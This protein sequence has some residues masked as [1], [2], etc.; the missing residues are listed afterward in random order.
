MT[1]PHDRDVRGRRAGGADARLR[2]L[3]TAAGVLAC[4]ALVAGCEGENLFDERASRG[5]GQDL[6]PPTVQ[7]LQPTTG[8]SV[9]H[10]DSILVEVRVQDDRGVRQ[11]VLSG[12]A[13]RGDA[14]LGTLVQIPRFE[15]KTVVLPSAPTDTTIRRF[16]RVLPNDTTTEEAV[17]VATVTDA[18]DNTAAQE[19]GILVGGP[20][21][22]ILQPTAGHQIQAGR[23]LA[24]RVEAGDAQGVE[25]VQINYSGLLTGTLLIPVSPSRD[26]ITID[27]AIAIPPGIAGTLQLSATVRSV[28]DV[29]RTSNVISV[30]VVNTVQPDTEQPF[31]GLA[32]STAPRLELTDS[33]RITVTARDDDGGSG[34]S[35]MGITVLAQNT[36]RTDTVVHTQQVTFP[37]PRAGTVTQTFAL[38][39]LNVDSLALP[40]TLILQVH[41]FAVDSAGNCSASVTQTQQRL[42]CGTFRGATIAA[43][44]V[45]MRADVIAVAGRT[46]PLPVNSLAADMVVDTLRH[47]IYVSNYF[48]GRVDLFDPAALQFRTPM[49][50]GSLPWGMTMNRRQDTLIVANSGG[51]NLSFLALQGAS[52][53]EDSPRRLLTPN[54]SLFEVK[55]E[56]DTLLA[57]FVMTTRYHDFSDRP[58]FVA[59]DSENR[60][61]F[62]TVP[63][64]AASPGVLRYVEPAPP[65]GAPELRLIVSGF[66]T[67]PPITKAEGTFAIAHLDSITPGVLWDHQPGYPDQIIRETL[68]ATDLDGGVGGVHS[69]FNRMFEAGSDLQ[70]YTG[71][72]WLI[73]ELSLQD[74]SFVAASADGTV[75]LF[76][77]GA[78]ANSPGK[79][80]RWEPA[81]R[82]ISRSVTIADLVSNAS[83]RVFGLAVNRDG[84]LAMARGREGVYF[85][86]RDL[87]LQGFFLDRLSV[88]TAGAALHP[89]HSVI[90]PSD[91]TTIAFVGTANRT[92]RIVDT[93]HFTQRGEI[94]LRDNIVGPLR[95]APPLPGDNTSTNCPNTDAPDCVL[96]RLYGISGSATAHEGIVSVPVRRRDLPPPLP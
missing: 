37:T 82:S 26:T 90:G 58:Q 81:R 27:T 88:G 6:L 42:Q 32:I 41:A 64:G 9:A 84:S 19:M 65:G 5:N 11:V 87:R 75:V 21:I 28:M 31:V 59:Q 54:A 24:I 16:L 67:Q 63:T 15:P 56:V 1:T 68:E 22:V 34:L 93:F 83:E 36:A 2:P 71:M 61:I 79:I 92:I 14:D 7:F 25:R 49:L 94:H 70:V 91:L 10:G 89:H 35:R 95:A 38:P 48:R 29:I 33:M 69:V 76:G 39:P 3:R 78:T 62:S 55:F 52:P 45:G 23:Q 80:I 66:L 12:V 47:R 53:V 85:F 74:T 86:T 20:R 50:V 57:T 51:T 17:L 43:S 13:R 8:A 96:V 60:L 77:E 72:R 30:V 44:A 18:G 73:P 46:I 40:N 4:F